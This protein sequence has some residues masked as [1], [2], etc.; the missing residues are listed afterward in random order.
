MARA[1][2]AISYPETSLDPLSCFD[3]DGVLIECDPA[4]SVVSS[5]IS[6]RSRIFHTLF[7]GAD[8]GR[9]IYWLPHTRASSRRGYDPD[10]PMVMAHFGGTN[11]EISQVSRRSKGVVSKYNIIFLDRHGRLWE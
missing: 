3:V 5:R 7:A 2:H 10:G 6:A 4:N 9:K 8:V 1:D 11:L